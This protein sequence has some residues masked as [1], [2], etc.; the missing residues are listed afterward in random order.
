[1]SNGQVERHRLKQIGNVDL[2]MCVELGRKVLSAEEAR[3]MKAG[4][5]IPLDKLAGATMDVIING[6]PFA[7][8]EIVVSGDRMTVRLT[9]M[10]EASD[11]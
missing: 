2:D 6:R 7:D 5:L 10:R 3:A 1:M 8:G 11:G 9:R 4:D